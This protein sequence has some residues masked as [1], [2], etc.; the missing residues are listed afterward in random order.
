MNPITDASLMLIATNAMLK[1]G[2][3]PRTTNRWEELD[4]TVQ[5]WDAWKTAYKSYNMKERIRCL[6]TGKN[7]ASH[8]ELR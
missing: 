4:D 2:D 6:D 8:G 3:F 7:A 1:T 5:T